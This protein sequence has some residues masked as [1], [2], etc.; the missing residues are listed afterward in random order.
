MKVLAFVF[1]F[2]RRKSLALFVVV[3]VVDESGLYDNPKCRSLIAVV[4]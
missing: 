4:S 2:L 1:L 3:V